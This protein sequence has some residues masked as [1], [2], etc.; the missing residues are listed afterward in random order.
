[1]DFVLRKIDEHLD[2]HL[3]FDQH[4]KYLKRKLKELNGLKKDTE[5]IMSIELQPRKK[6]KEEVQIW[7]ENVERINGEVQDLDGRMGG[8]SA[9]TRG[10]GRQ[11]VSKSIKEVEELIT[12]HRKFHGGL[13]VDNPQWIGQVLSATS[14]SG[15][16]VKA[17]IEEIWQCLMDDE[18]QKIGLWGMGGEGKTSIMKV[19]N[20]QL[21]KETGKFDIV[22]WITVS[23]QMSIAKLQKDIAG[24]IGVEFSG[25]E[26][27]TTRAGMLFETLS[28]KSRF[29]MILDDLWEKVSLERIGIPE[30]SNGSKLVL[31]T[32][33]FDVS[34][35]VGCRVIKVKPLM[36]E[37]AWKLFLEKV[38]FVIINIRGVEPIA[39]SMAKHCAGLPLGVITIASCMKGID[40]ISEWRN[41]LKE[42][43]LRKK[44]VNGFEDEV[45][46]QLQFSYDLL[47][48][49]KL[50][51]CFL[52]CALYP[53]DQEI[54]EGRLIRLWIGEGLVEEMDSMQAEFDRGRAIM[55]RLINNS[56]LEVF[57]ER[58][59]RR[60]VKM[61]DLL[62][63]MALHIAKSR[64]L[65]KSGTMLTEPPHVQEWSK[66]LEKVSLMSNPMLVIPPKMP[67]PKCP[68]LTTLL[69]SYCH[70]TSI[71]ENFFKHMHVLRILD[72]SENPIKNLPHSLS[73]C[74]KFTT[75]LLSD[76][77]IQSI[78]DGFFDQM[79]GLKILDLSENPIKSL[80]RSL[81]N[82]KNLTSLLLADCDDLE[83][84]PSLSNFKALKKLDLQ[85]TGIKEVP[86]G[87]ENLVS[88]EY[89][90]LGYF[91]N[92]NEIPN[93]IL[94]SLCCLQDLIVGVTPMSGKE[95]GGL[96]KLEI[97]KGRFNDCHNLNMYLQALRGRE[98]P[99][100]YIIY[101][102][103]VKWHAVFVDTRKL[104]VVSGCNIYTYQIVLPRD[105][106][107]LH[108]GDCDV[109]CGEEYPLFS[110][111]I[112]FSV[113][114]FS[115][116]KFLYM[117]DCRNMKKLFSP[118]CVPP[119]LQELRVFG[120]KQ[121]GEIIASEVEREKGGG[122]VTMEFRLPQ[123]RDLDLWDLPELKSICSVDAA[124]VCDSLVEIEILKCPKLKRM[125]LTLPQLDNVSSSASANLHLSIW[126]SPKEWWE[127]VEW[128]AK[129][130]LEP[131]VRE[132]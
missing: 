67:P 26:D 44:S 15:E 22:I 88:L 49:P 60:R 58:E 93:G 71:P 55:N 76:C 102:G 131:F 132:R 105:I 113:G 101:V 117:Y 33:S 16:A 107:G 77:G 106:E 20:N 100:Q 80:P 32:R 40:D 110:R 61:H 62:R 125:A 68:R 21:L 120:C 119:N 72:L 13:V 104:I 85:R 42:L 41:A 109:E 31:T 59:N 84:V 114:S 94:P 64:F 97:L 115:S 34:R 78:P 56:L 74:P 43:S 124:L 128:D 81:S 25:D 48:D 51:H 47:K 65:V 90:N 35:Q 5:S 103:D 29:V 46:Q 86:H 53:E 45:F 18:V 91:N 63:D 36:E 127:S 12:Q 99:L 28:Q 66:G 10:F 98:E 4:M 121:V 96:K 23:K 129:P 24:K 30:P 50:Q 83:N 11:D 69:L 39:R 17:C 19:I 73:K 123:L 6:L 95:V 2:N 116:L 54:D 87:M 92:L 52:S 9:L 89:L 37:E 82:L 111:F 130:L 79:N 75:L 126:I 27:E 14:L 1:M 70:I 8:S 122:I 57:T 3:S 108:V 7:L 38:G 118:N 112:L